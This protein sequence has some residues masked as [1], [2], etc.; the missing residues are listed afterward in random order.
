MKEEEN[1]EKDHMVMSVCSDKLKWNKI[2]TSERVA[3]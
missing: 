3:S 1:K 2:M